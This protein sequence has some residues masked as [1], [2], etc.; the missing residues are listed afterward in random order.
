M[1][2]WGEVADVL[3][4]RPT[5]PKSSPSPTSPTSL[6]VAQVAEK[7]GASVDRGTTTKKG[8]Q[9]G[10]F[11]P[12]GHISFFTRNKEPSEGGKEK[13]DKDKSKSTSSSSSGGGWLAHSR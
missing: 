1:R 11:S 12:C 6:D 8:M 2:T 5:S 13:K 3:P 9:R 7:R 4:S 10:G